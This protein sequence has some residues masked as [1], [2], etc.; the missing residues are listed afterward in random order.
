VNLAILQARTSSKRFPEKVLADLLGNPMIIRQINRIKKSKKIDEVVVATSSMGSDDKLCEI[1]KIH[2]I[3][4]FRGSLDN[5]L[6]RYTN[7]IEQYNPDLIIRL[8]G[9]CPLTD[10]E[11]I[12]FVIESHINSGADYSANTINPTFPDGLDVE[13]VKPEILQ[14]LE[15]LNPDSLEREHVTYGLYTRKNFCSINSIE[16]TENLSGHR[17]TVD[18]PE[19]L[20]FVRKIYSYFPGNLEEFGQYDILRILELNP[21][22]SRTNLD[23]ERN[24]GLNN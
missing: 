17:W 3:P 15:G 24:S 21:S 6:S 14:K 23:L 8:T 5:V 13:C 12:D 18:V 4:F 20:D 11:V 22:L 16:Q 2:N 1:L 10:P 9:D 7:I 19:D